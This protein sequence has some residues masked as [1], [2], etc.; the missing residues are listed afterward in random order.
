MI[1]WT[2]DAASSLPVVQRYVDL[3]TSRVSN[4]LQY[5]GDYRYYPEMKLLPHQLP[6]GVSAQDP[7][8]TAEIV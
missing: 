3:Y 5:P 6:A 1:V 4:F 7:D 2:I 8:T